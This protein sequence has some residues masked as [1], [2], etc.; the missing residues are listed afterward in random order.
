VEFFRRVEG[1]PPSRV[2]IAKPEPSS[3]TCVIF[4]PPDDRLVHA[5][6]LPFEDLGESRAI[7]RLRCYK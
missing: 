3:N 7:V 1:I 5:S 2:T 6:T 4:W